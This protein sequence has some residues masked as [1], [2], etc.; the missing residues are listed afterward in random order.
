[1]GFVMVQCGV[2]FTLPRHSS[3]SLFPGRWIPF[4]KI[5]IGK[6]CTIWFFLRSLSLSLCLCLCLCLWK[7]LS[8]LFLVTE[9]ASVGMT[10]VGHLVSV[11]SVLA[12]VK[13]PVAVVK[14]KCFRLIWILTRERI[15]MVHD[16]TKLMAV[17]SNHVFGTWKLSL[18]LGC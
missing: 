3:R 18:P 13:A 5:I 6:P 8:H 17:A 16:W 14:C 4:G 1:M 11:S 7:S 10:L 15:N 12:S 2:T 9:L